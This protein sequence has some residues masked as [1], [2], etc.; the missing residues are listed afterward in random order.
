MELD[1]NAKRILKKIVERHGKEVALLFKEYGFKAP[2]TVETVVSAF[3]ANQGKFVDDLISIGVADDP[4]IIPDNLELFDDEDLDESYSQD[5]FLG[6]GKPG[7]PEKG[8]K[9]AA[10][11][12]NIGSLVTGAKILGKAAKN[13]SKENASIAK[14]E[15]EIHSYQDKKIMGISS[16]IFYGSAVVVSLI[17]ILLLVN[18]YKKN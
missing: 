14:E 5:G 2:V 8:K 6:M 15:A 10:L 12:N 3:V 17:I 13:T 11:F 4:E 18:H 7:N 1:E 9:L 16:S